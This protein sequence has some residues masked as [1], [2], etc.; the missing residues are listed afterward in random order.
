M[1]L[2][3][4]RS[5]EVKVGLL[6]P[7]KRNDTEVIVGTQGSAPLNIIQWH[8]DYFE[9]KLLEKQPMLKKLERHFDPR[10]SILLEKW[11]KSPI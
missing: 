3:P 9:V 11:N 4:S 2:G 7:L 10:L 6:E 8:T 5:A 1:N